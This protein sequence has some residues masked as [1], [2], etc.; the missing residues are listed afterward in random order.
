MQ[1]LISACQHEPWKSIVI[2]VMEIGYSHH[3]L[4]NIFLK[5]ALYNYV[6]LTPTPN[7]K[8]KLIT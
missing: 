7:S 4:K 3:Q 8:V 2:I 5:I 6:C 1:S